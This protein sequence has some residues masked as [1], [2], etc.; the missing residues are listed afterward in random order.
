MKK[1]FAMFIVAFL[2]TF[3]LS[4]CDG[5]KP[6]FKFDLEV[7]GDVSDTPTSIVAD[8]NASVTNV[9][10]VETQTMLF[11]AAPTKDITS[12][13]GVDAL[14]W[15]DDYIKTNV[16]DEMGP[17]TVYEIK[18]KGYVHEKVTGLTFSVDKKFS[19]KPPTVE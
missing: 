6:E 9:P 1:F 12:P 8:F 7:S 10:V 15:L 2:A 14:Q 13:E 4:S 19:N 3:A 16:L 5:T 11:S 18:V 17:E